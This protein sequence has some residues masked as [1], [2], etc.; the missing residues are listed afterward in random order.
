M[1]VKISVKLDAAAICRRYGLGSSDKAQKVLA[2][3][4]RRRCDKYVP[5]DQG[6]LKNTAQLA[7]NG[8]TITYIQ[9]YALKQYTI[10]YRHKDN[11]RCRY[12]DR[13]MMAAEG[14]AVVKD[15]EAYI[16][17]RPG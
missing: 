8:A 4:V 6:P 12:W 5:F 17:G 3:N 16:K 11:R 7:A 13:V 9:S 14:D 2:A 10:P 1:N 15:L